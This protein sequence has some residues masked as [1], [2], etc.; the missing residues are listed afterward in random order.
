M[1]QSL[2]DLTRRI[3]SELKDLNRAVER[4]G[5]AW[6]RFKTS[7]DDSYVDSAALNLHGFYSGLERLFE[8]TA[9]V[10][11][12]SKPTGA[13]WH[14]ELLK[15][16]S[17]E[18]PTIRPAVISEDTREKLDEYRRFRHLVRNVYTFK[19]DAGKMIQL[20]EGVSNLYQQAYR[21]LSIFADFLEQRARDTEE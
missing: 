9:T 4:A 7:S 20:V 6:K 2:S 11:D 3:R 21:E 8:L 16:M 17:T 14:Q 1:N 10:V 13:E 19:L 18:M 15:Q 5:L 12:K